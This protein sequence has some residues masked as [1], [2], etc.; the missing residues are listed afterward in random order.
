ML[1]YKDGFK[2]AEADLELR[3]QGDFF[4][5]KQSGI[6]DMHFADIIKDIKIIQQVKNDVA[7]ILE[8]DADLSMKKNN[9]LYNRLKVMYKDSTSYFG[10]G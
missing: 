5:T 10:I 7:N 3:G 2:L 4:G 6:P 8:E 1:E 9:I